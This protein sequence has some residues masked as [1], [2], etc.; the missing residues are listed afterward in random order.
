MTVIY[1]FNARTS[2][3]R[4]ISAVFSTDALIPADA[5]DTYLLPGQ[6]GFSCSG[7][8]GFHFLQRSVQDMLQYNDAH[9]G[10]ALSF[11]IPRGAFQQ[12]GTFPASDVGSG[13]GTLVVEQPQ[14]QPVTFR[15]TM[16][17]SSGR[18]WALGA[19]ST[20]EQRFRAAAGGVPNELGIRMGINQNP[21]AVHLVVAVDG[22]V[23]HDQTHPNLVQRRS[24]WAT[25]FSLAD[26]T[27]QVAA[28]AWVTVRITPDREIGI[29]PLFEQDP[30]VPQGQLP[31]YGDMAARFYMAGMTRP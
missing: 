5:P 8:R 10:G 17:Q 4:D 13:R 25:V 21:Y 15:S 29:E 22:N 28:G 14:P 20:F 6:G 1:R 31:R 11:G 26:V 7:C 30:D 19:G 12:F 18:S 16:D 24:D 2:D 27:A 3:G 9:T 23:L